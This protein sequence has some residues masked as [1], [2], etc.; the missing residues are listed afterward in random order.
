MSDFYFLIADANN[1]R[2]IPINPDYGVGGFIPFGVNGIFS[3]SATFMFI[4]I[5]FESIITFRSM[6]KDTQKFTNIAFFISLLVPFCAIM[7]VGMILTFMWPYND[8]NKAYTS[9]SIR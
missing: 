7:G 1:W 8:V 3:G 5:G 2:I 9:T 4:F 6:G